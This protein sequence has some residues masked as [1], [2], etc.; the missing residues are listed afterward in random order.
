MTE[1]NLRYAYVT[2]QLHA[3]IDA[4]E[5]GQWAYGDYVLRTAQVTE[6]FLCK[7]FA[8]FLQ[9]QHNVTHTGAK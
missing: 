8:V 2:S 3:R 4:V 9:L 7:Q 6:Q 5:Y 1:N